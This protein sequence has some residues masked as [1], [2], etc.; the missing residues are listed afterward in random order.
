MLDNLSTIFGLLLTQ[1]CHWF[2]MLAEPPLI[3][4]FDALPPKWTAEEEA[5]LGEE[6]IMLSE[7]EAGPRLSPINDTVSSA[8]R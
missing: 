3:V 5:L 1:F 7:A 4:T 2:R 8:C 6:E